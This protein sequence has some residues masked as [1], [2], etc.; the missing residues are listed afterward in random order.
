MML[1]SLL[2]RVGG[3]SFLWS[4]VFIS[5]VFGQRDKVRFTSLTSKDGLSS[6]KVNAILK[7][8]YG[9]MWF[10]TEDGLNKFDG[11]TFTVYRHSETDTTTLPSNDVLSFHEDNAG[12]L[13]VAT[14][15]GSISLYD[16]KKDSFK[17][18]ASYP[19]FDG[20]P[21]V[22]RSICSDYLGNL[23]LASLNGLVRFNPKS[24]KVTRYPLAWS[25]TFTPPT[26]VWR[27][28]E[29]SRRRL[30][31][32][33]DLGL[34]L[35]DRRKNS[36]IRFKH[37]DSDPNS[38]SCDSVRSIAEDRGGSIWI[39]TTNG[40]SR[41]APG[42]RKFT[43]YSHTRPGTLSNSSIHSVA[44]DRHGNLWIA[45]SSGL[46]ILNLQTANFVVYTSDKRDIHSLTD[47]TIQHIYFDSRGIG[48]LATMR[49]GVNKFD[50]NL[51]LF[52][53]KQSDPF[54]GKG[55]SASTVTSFAEDKSGNVFVGTDGG[56]L[57]LFNRATGLFSHLNIRASNGT[58]S[59]R[60]QVLAL[61]QDRNHQLWV[62][63]YLTGLFR[64][65]PE[66]GRYQQF[67]SGAKRTMLTASDVICLKEDR[68]GNIWVGTNGGGLNKYDPITKTFENYNRGT[69]SEKG[70]YLPINPY[71]RAIAEDA[72]GNIWV[73]SHG[74]GIAIL[75]PSGNTRLYNRE[76]SALPNDFVLSILP[77]RN[78]TI[79][80][81]TLGGG[82]SFLDR[83]TGKFISFSEKQGLA[84]S[85]IYKIMEDTQGILWMSTNN[86]ISS[87]NPKTRRF[88]NFT[89]YHGL[90]NNNFAHGAGL[91]LSD[92]Q[93]FFGGLDGFNYFYPREMNVNS[94][95]PRA[96]LTDLKV[97][98]EPVL[99]GKGAPTAEHIS[100]AK[101]ITINY[102]QNV[103]LSFVALDFSMPQQ[104]NYSYKLEG[105]TKSWN[106][107]GSQKTASYINLSPGD[108]T[109]K[110]RVGNSDG[111][112]G[113]VTTI[114]LH[115]L[116]PF[117]MSVYAYVAYVLFVVGLLLFIRHRGI[118]KL[119]KNFKMEQ[120]RKEAERSRELDLLKIKFLT[121]L[122]HEFRTPISLIMGPVDR[123]IAERKDASSAIQLKMIK[124]NASRLLDLANQLLDF[125]KMEEHELKLI[126]SDGDL[127]SF[128]KEVS[129]SFIDLSERK[130][131]T[132][133]FSSSLER[134]ES[135]FD[136]DKIERV[137]LNLLS[138]AFKF[139]S[140]GGMI[141]L[142]LAR[143]EAESTAQ[144][145]PFVI[146]KI[147]DT[148]IGIPQDDQAQIFER[149]FQSDN[150]DAVL[151][152]G[153]GIGLSITREFV[154]LL[155]GSI[156]VESEPGKGSVFTIRLPFSPPLGIAKPKVDENE[157]EADSAGA[158]EPVTPELPGN[159]LAGNSLPVILLVEDN[160]DF[161]SYLKDHLK[162]HYKV[163][164]ASNGRE[165]WQK[166]L[167][168]HP[169]VIVTDVSM[170]LMDGIELCRKI[171]SDKRTNH[172][173]IILLTALT[174]TTEQI[175]G[176]ETGANDYITKPFN[177]DI[178][179]VKIKN[180]LLLN[181]NL[182]SAY[183]KQ[184]KIQVPDIEIESNNDKL[185]NKV[186]LYIGNNIANPALSVEDLSKH[187]GMSRSTLYYK[188]LELTGESP[189]EYIRSVKLE[190]AA[191]LL[192]K[193]D[194]NVGQVAYM[195]GFTSPTYFSKSFK[196]KFN[197]QPSE[198]IQMKRKGASVNDQGIEDK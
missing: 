197:M 198:Y 78:N 149:F 162:V 166:A 29:D 169:Q 52:D 41:W 157:A 188:I 163:L 186:A 26:T 68:K 102:K 159:E 164:E 174:A 34:F 107:V 135:N 189:V 152:Q 55:L 100:M 47:N 36:F 97:D 32:G 181:K 53:L 79:W 177:F 43:N 11:T 99:P 146:L 9:Y 20:R 23:W 81:G 63:T 48:W 51:S 66:T 84:N 128:V 108:Y 118:L 141:K 185:L 24:T 45:T 125:R 106:N 183:V 136:H 150:V 19:G 96:V 30:W 104:Y 119:K 194:L 73:G 121:N 13:W 22:I 44:A 98:N 82:L 161:R 91:E 147:T 195:C 175:E 143:S 191:T 75:N 180:L 182:K 122:S 15:V 111:K 139:T 123:L 178:L 196:A 190:R 142:E 133:T 92:G 137:L 95:I 93:F 138:N 170:P 38:L 69:E 151:N 72:E 83:K 89:H 167:S 144:K 39:G 70:V 87:F 153:S 1:T 46:N 6:N 113:E 116:P 132:F 76:N 86:G 27:V 101:R 35:Y 140:Q 7:D 28:F 112:Y 129:D 42:G 14:N 109:F 187:A 158:D 184:V 80:V 40:L 154:K 165:G 171:R 114:L 192:E 60:L 4:L 64:F 8:R 90:Q 176:L 168:Y 193:S 62:G 134:L 130:G 3:F 18:F 124:R 71:I 94:T 57:S 77:D 67:L 155:G 5:S 172:L 12:N 56:G 110:V 105:L 54:D 148:G 120:E 173:P 127:V 37:L 10:A 85:V 25:G 131:I 74:S 59:S 49:G 17:S 33:T 126:A 179:N 65:D 31:V 103:S 145:D 16:R 117:W 58:P 2:K 61:E 115:V 50:K 156:L 160:F 88:K 21:W